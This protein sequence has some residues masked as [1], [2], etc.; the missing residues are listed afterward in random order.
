MRF[1][2]KQGADVNSADERGNTALMMAAWKGNIECVNRVIKHG[3]NVNATNQIGATALMW[4]AWDGRS[5]CV[6]LLLKNGADVNAKNRYQD[7][8]LSYAVEGI[9]DPACIKLLRAAMK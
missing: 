5:A 2:L 4:A 6:K 7:D 3:A 1:C 8:A 9:N